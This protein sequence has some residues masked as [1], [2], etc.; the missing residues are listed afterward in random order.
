[1]FFE[2]LLIKRP[3]GVFP[4]FKL[5]V[6]LPWVTDFEGFP[7]VTVLAHVMVVLVTCII[8]MRLFPL[9]TTLLCI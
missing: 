5:S 2:F 4:L 9:Y 1:M 6:L 3:R 8:S 7:P